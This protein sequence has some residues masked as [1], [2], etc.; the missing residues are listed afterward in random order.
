MNSTDASASTR[1]TATRSP[2]ACV[3]CRSRHLKC[4]GKRPYCT[5]CTEVTTQCHYAKSRRGGLDR[6]ALA[7]RRKRLATTNS[8]S[9]ASTPIRATSSQALPQLHQDPGQIFQRTGVHIQKNHSLLDGLDF[10]EGH[11]GTGSLEV[12]LLDACSIEDDSLIG[13]YFKNFHGFHPMVL[14]RKHLTR[15]HQEPSRQS[16]LKPLIAVLRFIGHLYG[17]LEWSTP[18]KE[19]LESCFSEA[20][21]TDPVM[22]QCRLLYSIA[23]FWYGHKNESK[24]EMDAA[25]RLA[26]DLEMFRR[27]FAAVHG[28]GDP[29]LTE[30][31]RRTWWA[32]YIVDAYIA[33]TLGTMELA[34][35]NVEATVDLPCEECEYESGVGLILHPL[36][37]NP[38]RLRCLFY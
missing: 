12:S 2:L 38:P 28:D 22:V 8:T 23:L 32:L 1:S 25:V 10:T 17:S 7:E 4:D 30:S 36:H 31:W 21:A 26:L 15:H 19:Q 20:S 5:R 3:P 13:L 29:V 35:V 33:G 9:S 27:E 6:A 11:S 34:V 14:P 37:C 24:Q 18:L 16:S